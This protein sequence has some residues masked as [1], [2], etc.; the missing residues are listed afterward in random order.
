VLGA[1]YGTYQSATGAIA[2]FSPKNGE[3]SEDTETLLQDAVNVSR[4]PRGH[5][6]AL[7]PTVMSG[8]VA[9]YGLITAVILAAQSMLARWSQQK[10]HG[11]IAFFILVQCRCN[12]ATT[13]WLQ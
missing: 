11:E 10:P 1:A 3:Y 13:R 12:T 5:L 7:I 6:Y 2:A 8:V 9:I 4:H